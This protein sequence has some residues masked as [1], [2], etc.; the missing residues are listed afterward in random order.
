[1][2]GCLLMAGLAG[3]Q[4]YGTLKAGSE[5]ERAY[6]EYATERRAQAAEIQRRTGVSME[7]SAREEQRAVGKVKSAAAGAGLRV[8]GSVN[9]LEQAV[10]EQFRRERREMGI[11]TAF[12]AG[13][14][15]REAYRLRRYGK[16]AKKTSQIQA[17]TGA[18]GNLYKYGA[19][20]RWWEGL[21]EV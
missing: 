10:A 2:L 16:E 6:K 9:R 5:E 19:Q 17:F 7:E 3:M 13:Q 21:A 20:K 18:L 15:E 1:M 8:A 4:G 14:I 11:Q 12:E